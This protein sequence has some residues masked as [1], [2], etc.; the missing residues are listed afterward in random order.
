MK[1]SS[2]I[3]LLS[4]ALAL[5]LT[6]CAAAAR[7]RP[8]P[9]GLISEWTGNGTAAD[10]T[11][12]NNGVL[13]GGARFAPGH[14]AKAFDFNGTSG[15]VSI[16]STKG[17]DFAPN[18][19]F[20]L[21]AWVKPAEIGRYEAIIVRGDPTGFWDWGILIDPGGHFYTGHGG[22]DV[23]Q[24]QTVALPGAWYF[25]TVTYTAGA[26]KMYVDG[27]QE[28][29]AADSAL[30]GETGAIAIGRKGGAT[31]PDQTNF[32]SGLV[33]DVRVYSRAL[34]SD[35]I[36]RDYASEEIR[37]PE[38]Q[39]PLTGYVN[40]F[41][42]TAGGGN[43]FPGATTPFGMTQLSPDTMNNGVGYDYGAQ[44]IDGFSMLHMSGVGCADYGDVFMTASTG[45]VQPAETAYRSPFSHA[46]E[47]A[48]PGYYR[49]KLEKP[50]VLVELT[51][52]T[53]CGSARFTFP[54]GQAGNFLLPISHTLVT[55]NAAHALIP[56]NREIEGSVTS[57]GFCGGGTPYTVYYVIQF[58]RPFSHSGT[59]MN[60]VVTAGSRE[61]RQDDR[62]T[63]IG[64]YAT[65]NPVGRKPTVVTANIGISFVD[66]AG[67]RNNLNREIS[68]ESFDA[69]RRD[70][71]RAWTKILHVIDVTGGTLTQRINFYTALYHA[72]L[73][74]NTFSDEDNRF[75]GFDMKVRQAP[76]GRTI[77]ANFSGWDIYRTEVP[78]LAI[79]EPD[80]LADMAQS[81]V[82]EYQQ[83]GRFDRWPMANTPTG[84]MNGEP[85]TSIQA[86]T[87][88]YGIKNFN[89]AA[90]Y[91]GMYR[92]A[93]NYMKGRVG[94]KGFDAGNVSTM[95]EYC[96]SIAALSYIADSLGRLGDAAQLRAWSE[97]VFNLY[98]PATGFFQPRQK[99][100]TWKTPF[101]PTSGNGYVEGTAW[102]YL[103]LVPQDVAGL[104][105]R[106][107]GDT[108][109]NKRLDAFFSYPR[110]TWSGQYY[111]PYN[112]P[113]L[114]APFLYDY[115][116]EP[117][118]T[119]SR[120]RE[121]QRDAY[122]P[123]PGGIPGNDDC[124]T[125][126]SWYV[127]SAL[128]LYAVDPG[129]PAMELTSPLFPKAVVHLQTGGREFTV[130]AP[131]NSLTTPY[132]ES[133]KI[134]GRS[135]GR[136]W[137]PVYVITRGGHMEYKLGAKPNRIWGAAPRLRPPSLSTLH[138]TLSLRPVLR[139][140]AADIGP[141]AVWKDT[142]GKPIQAHGGGILL[143]HGVYYWYGE[144][145]TLGYNNKVGVS[146]YSSRDLRTWRR[147]GVVLPKEALPAQFQDTGVCERPKVIYN[148]KTGKYVMWMHLDANHYSVS[149]A[150]VAT[151]DQPEG[152]FRFMGAARPIP[153]STFRDMNLFVDDNGAAYVFF[154]GDGNA[155]MYAV[156]LN[157]DYT[158]P[159][160]PL[161][162]GKT[163]ARALPKAWREAPAPFKYGNRY[164]LI[165]SGCTGWAPNAA[166]VSVADHILG[167]WKTEGNPCVGPD[168]KTTFH[169]QS[170]F[171]IP[172]PG[173]DPGRFIFGADQWNPRDL[174]DS[175]YLWLPFHI[176]GDGSFHLRWQDRLDPARNGV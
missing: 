97:E 103:W 45:P 32:F 83:S 59:W 134:N 117:W 27:D 38:K 39:R 40:P 166:S 128:G 7:P 133:L 131:H 105:R 54:A 33:Q 173:S 18:D 108:V 169:S 153:S 11:G 93:A 85:T 163:W 151:A 23:A 90:S 88:D 91:P 176:D 62:K 125:M 124:G 22:H 8:M 170:A 158:G 37:V 112:E 44:M 51:A 19:S 118:K 175:R 156:R 50:G 80:R 56:N 95:E 70:A 14:G 104:I 89:M 41:V 159:A 21:N 79:I 87:W 47:A 55:T 114:Q 98:N 146:C 113:D 30:P 20:T 129:R 84:V 3:R 115:S 29:Q 75:I 172:A 139:S 119:Q 138:S 78:L 101:D 137:A 1:A 123:A 122:S 52:A 160:T 36:A 48:S 63:K 86:T 81:L 99:D 171:V 24:S 34:S 66:L 164:Y 65:F 116:G 155:S 77:Y 168:A 127:L 26:Y 61:V 109:F 49:V 15:Y 142:E 42:G 161:V 92:A 76:R 67:A 147:V 35:E 68:G 25:V 110:P 120:V 100:G 31:G 10:S 162:E 136:A 135:Y 5:A 130:T 12:R 126:S 111:N 53:R 121:L 58:D 106:M 17:L 28:N 2:S 6:A 72:L 73:M 165:T 154:S 13:K 132:V 46:S 60:D 74:P 167:P 149:T 64:A 102:H 148:Q 141:G 145:H 107:G 94:A 157:D 4:A 150:G 143:S 96:Y 69:V 16:P 9:S 82:Y 174:A 43:T 144:D 152:P 71:D 57:Q 140:P